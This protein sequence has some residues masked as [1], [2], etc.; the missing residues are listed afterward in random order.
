MTAV[1]NSLTCTACIFV[2]VPFHCL[3]YCI[4]QLLFLEVVEASWNLVITVNNSVPP[5]LHLYVL[6]TSILDHLS[7]EI[8]DWLELLEFLYLVIGLLLLLLIGCL[9]LGHGCIV[10]ICVLLAEVAEG[11]TLVNFASSTP[12]MTSAVI[13]HVLDITVHIWIQSDPFSNRLKQSA[14]HSLGH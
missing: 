8:Q 2:L 3:I 12:Q 14:I 9:L 4:P 1:N 5:Q 11:M 7:L 10:C 6:N 13:R